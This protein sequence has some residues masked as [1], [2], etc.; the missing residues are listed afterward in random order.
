VLG[1]ITWLPGDGRH[2]AAARCRPSPALAEFVRE[3]EIIGLVRTDPRCLAV[4]LPYAGSHNSLICAAH[5]IG[6]AWLA[7]G[8]P[9]A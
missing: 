3:G 7:C 9:D 2:L 1:G 8:M 5:P 6:T 4:P